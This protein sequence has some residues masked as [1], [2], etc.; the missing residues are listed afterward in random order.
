M[1]VYLVRHTSV[2]VP[3]GICYGQSDVPLK[4]TFP[5]EAG[6]VKCRLQHLVYKGILP[7][8]NSCTAGF[9]EEMH[10]GEPLL[11]FD[12]V[13]TSPLDRCT[14]LAE[15]CGY[16]N[17]VKEPRILELNFGEW[18]MQEY[19][20][21]KDPHLEVWFEDWI[22][23]RTTGGES[24]MDQYGRVSAFLQELKGK[25]LENVL[26][27]CHGGVLACAKVLGGKID[28]SEAFSTLDDYGSILHISL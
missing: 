20:E 21:I 15:F 25:G 19:K 27:F 9:P 10:A 4:E 2:D 1:N 28:P 26:L 22:N 12:A 13:Y 3:R 8:N 7:D 14:R 17:A 24:F 5:Q 23:V 16:G 18:E 6:A 11:S